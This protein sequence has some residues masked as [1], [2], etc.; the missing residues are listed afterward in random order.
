MVRKRER[1]KG[2]KRE[3]NKITVYTSYSNRAYMRGYYNKCVNM[4]IFRRTNVENF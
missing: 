1:K 3:I 4:H 2:A